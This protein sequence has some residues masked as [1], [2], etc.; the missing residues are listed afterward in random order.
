MSTHFLA[1]VVVG[2]DLVVVVVGFSVGFEVVEEVGFSV[3][4]EVVGPS[5]GLWVVDVGASVDVVVPSVGDGVVGAPYVKFNWRIENNNKIEK[6]NFIFFIS[7]LFPL[8][9]LI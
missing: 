1:A 2:L 4:I 9:V 3:G 6:N 5:V 7:F 8:I